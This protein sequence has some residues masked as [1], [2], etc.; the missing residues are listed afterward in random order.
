MRLMFLLLL[1]LPG[2]GALSSLREPTREVFDLAPAA[3]QPRRC[4]RTRAGE[5]VVELPKARS[6]LDTDRI[7]VRPAPLQVQYLPDARWG[8]SV[9]VM[10]Q[11][12]LVR[13]FGDH[14]AFA[15]VGR[16][17]LG[18][19]GDLAL[20][21]EVLD[22]SAAPE[23]GGARVRMEVEA[24]LVREQD[25]RIMARGRFATEAAAAGLETGQLVPAFDAA[26]RALTGQ[27]ADWGLRAVGVRPET[28]RPAGMLPG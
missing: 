18:S 27:V 25:A 28:C 24:Q 26:A 2:C 5:L 9:P 12:M 15:R 8:D 11:D 17:P 19:S 23:A 21:S 3:A 16:A 4:G 14:D 6:T 20:V 13:A 22:F 10:L 1:A 7:M